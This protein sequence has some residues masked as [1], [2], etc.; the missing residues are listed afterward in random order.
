[1]RDIDFYVLKLSCSTESILVR[2]RVQ[3]GKR[4]RFFLIPGDYY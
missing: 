3:M 2:T 1:M 4:E